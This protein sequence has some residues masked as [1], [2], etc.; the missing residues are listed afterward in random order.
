MAAPSTRNGIIAT[1]AFGKNQAHEGRDAEH[2]GR[3]SPR[4]DIVVTA[5]RII[6]PTDL[7][8]ISFT[9]IDL[10]LDHPLKR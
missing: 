7:G 2:P 10:D 8:W 3:E 5:A 1:S 4:R 6:A 9:L